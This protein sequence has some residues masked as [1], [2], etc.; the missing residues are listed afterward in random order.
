M[1]RM[2]PLLAA[3]CSRLHP[4]KRPAGWTA[5]ASI[6]RDC[7]IE[8]SSVS[9]PFMLSWK[10]LLMVE[11]SMG[12]AAPSAVRVDSTGTS[13]GRAGMGGAGAGV[14]AEAGMRMVGK[15]KVPREVWVGSPGGGVGV[16]SVSSGAAVW[17]GFG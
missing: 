12:A 11:A 15:V 10:A 9:L 6:T 5:A 14:G 4:E 17:A 16:C 7:S 13:A 1:I 2:C 8:A 3:A